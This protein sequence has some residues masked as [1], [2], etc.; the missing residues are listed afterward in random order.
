MSKHKEGE[1]RKRKQT[2]AASCSGSNNF[3][4]STA[5][6]PSMQQQYKMNGEASEPHLPSSASTPPTSTRPDPTPCPSHSAR[7]SGGKNLPSKPRKR[8][9]EPGG[10][11]NIDKGKNVVNKYVK[12]DKN[13]KVSKKGNNSKKKDT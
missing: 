11:I 8:K 1:Q 5:S 9:R 10:D 4:T 12:R 13:E 3:Q 2:N 7:L 6:P